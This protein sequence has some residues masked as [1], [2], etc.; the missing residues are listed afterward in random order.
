MA[1]RLATSCA[2]ILWIGRVL[3]SRKAA[4]RLA[5]AGLT[6][7]WS[8]A[9]PPEPIGGTAI[10]RAAKVRAKRGRKSSQARYCVRRGWT[11][12]RNLDGLMP[13]RL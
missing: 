2:Q 1:E 12:A 9:A 11:A 3:T 6:G 7:I 5:L 8:A 4:S 10:E 13:K